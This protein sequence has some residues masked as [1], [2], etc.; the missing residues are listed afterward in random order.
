MPDRPPSQDTPDTDLPPED[1]QE[2]LGEELPV[3][4][5][6]VLEL[7]EIETPRQPTLTE[8]DTGAESDR[9]RELLVEAT[10]DEEIT[11]VDGLIDDAS[12]EIAALRPDSTS[13][14]E[15]TD[16]ELREGETTDPIEA[17]EEGE[18]W[19][20]PTDP[21]V[22]PV[23][24]DPDG[25]E[26]PGFAE[27]DEAE[28]SVNAEIREALRSDASTSGLADRLEIA[29][30]GSTAVIRGVVDGIED[31]DAIVDV[32]SRVDGIDDVRDE[33]EVAGL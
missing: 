21:P 1:V 23:T 22:V 28:G 10:E 30:I 33:T 29:V 4:Q 32:V 16:E 8:R 20:P 15:L 18:V 13:L 25:I 17:T 11:D 9:D 5:D 27:L 19:V 2:L 6:A 24:G 12:S 14:D 31:S 26:V 3:D 7:D